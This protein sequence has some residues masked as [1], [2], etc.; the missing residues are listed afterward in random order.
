VIEETILLLCYN[1]TNNNKTVTMYEYLKDL[2]KGALTIDK[3]RVSKIYNTYEIM[4]VEV[5][6]G[7]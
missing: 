3:W 4:E 7:I 6:M 5:S 1:S 2:R